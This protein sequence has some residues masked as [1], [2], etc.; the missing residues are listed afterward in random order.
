MRRFDKV[1]SGALTFGGD[2]LSFRS[3]GKGI[4]PTPNG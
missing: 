4:Q 2:P 1:L 3:Q